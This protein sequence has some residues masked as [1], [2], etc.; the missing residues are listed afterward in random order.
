MN[1]V[2]LDLF[3]GRVPSFIFTRVSSSYSHAFAFHEGIF[4][5]VNERTSDCQPKKN[6]AGKLALAYVSYVTPDLLSIYRAIAYDVYGRDSPP[7]PDVRFVPWRL[8]NP[9]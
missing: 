6:L 7:E 8:V 5:S 3:F 4:R 2:T 1:K 9:A